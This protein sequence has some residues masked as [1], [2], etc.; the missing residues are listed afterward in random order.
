MARIDRINL[1]EDAPKPTTI[2]TGAMAQTIS[3]RWLPK[4]CEGVLPPRNRMSDVTMSAATTTKIAQQIRK[5]T[6]NRCRIV[7]ASGDAGSS[8][9]TVD[10]ASASVRKRQLSGTCISTSP[11]HP[12]NSGFNQATEPVSQNPLDAYSIN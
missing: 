2:R 4:T 10:A 9:G 1:V 7:A 11:A 5:T 3:D 6:T 12:E 8:T